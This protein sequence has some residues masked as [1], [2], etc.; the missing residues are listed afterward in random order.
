LQEFHADVARLSLA[1]GRND[2]R[3]ILLLQEHSPAE[4]GRMLGIPRSTVHDQ[5]LRLRRSFVG[6]G[7]VPN[8]GHAQT[9]RRGGR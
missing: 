6:A 5:I 7:F 8:R 1:F 9:A 3:L 4:A 2:R